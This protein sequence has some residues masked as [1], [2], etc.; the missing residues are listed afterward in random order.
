M[1]YWWV[2]QNQTYKKEIR[3]NFMWSPKT[4]GQERELR[5]PFYDYM[6][7]VSPGDLVFS[8]KDTRIKAVGV[9]MGPAQTAPKPDFGTAGNNWSE[10][11][12]YVPVVYCGFDQPIRP[13]DH[14]DVLRPFLPSQHSP[15]QPNGNGNQGI[16]LTAVPPPLAQALIALV[17]E[18][19]FNHAVVEASDPT[20]IVELEESVAVQIEHVLPPTFKEQL[21]KARRGQGVFRSNVLL[22][23]KYCRVTEVTNP[24]H[25]RA[26]HIK[27]WSTSNDAER[28][29]GFN[30][31]L[32]S[33]HVDHLF[34]EGYISF[35]N[36]QELLVAPEVEADLL[37]KWGI[38]PGKRVGDFNRDQQGF[39]EIHRLEIFK[40]PWP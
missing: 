10:E 9:V 21:V 27:P 31:L 16:Y 4:K 7:K 35:S 39:L 38:E 36:N 22:N 29:N 32:L 18:D 11:G 12:W 26:S 23:E 14:I 6:R 20:S 17:G 15:L 13:K 28:L 2:N 33:P 5:N 19:V 30:G 24:R 8:F 3:G 34:D 25:L 37:D 40:G 1:R